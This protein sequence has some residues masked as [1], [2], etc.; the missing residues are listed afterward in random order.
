MLSAELGEAFVNFAWAAPRQPEAEVPVH[1]R[2]PFYVET[3][4]Y[5]IHACTFYCATAITYP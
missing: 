2:L 5:G 3:S 1:Q 4:V